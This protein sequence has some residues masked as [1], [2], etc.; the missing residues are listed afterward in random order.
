[1]GLLRP[2]QVRVPR[3]E[4]PPQARPV[5]GQ[6]H[7]TGLLQRVP[8]LVQQAPER[9][10]QASQAA[11]RTD[12]PQQVLARVRQARGLGPALASPSAHRKDLLPQVVP[13]ALAQAWRAVRQKDLLPQGREQVP[14]VLVPP[15]VLSLAVALVPEQAQP[16]VPSLAAEQELALAAEQVRRAVLWLAVALAQEQVPLVV[17]SPEGARPQAVAQ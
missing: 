6:A 2:A 11:R 12:L 7:Q 17:L 1:M 5:P 8:G 13:L 15:E 16:V 14:R 3:P 9:V 10:Q 4:L